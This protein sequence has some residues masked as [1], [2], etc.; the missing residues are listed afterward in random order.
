[1]VFGSPWIQRQSVSGL[2]NDTSLAS[3]WEATHAVSIPV[4]GAEDAASEGEQ[5]FTSRER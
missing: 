3:S 4:F 5:A 2:G 1:M